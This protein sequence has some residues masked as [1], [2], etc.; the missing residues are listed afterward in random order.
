MAGRAMEGQV[1]ELRWW[2]AYLWTLVLTRTPLGPARAYLVARAPFG[3]RLAA[4]ALPGQSLVEY[5]LVI[6]VIALV[7]IAGLTAF[8]NGITQ[9]FTT[10]LGRVTGAVG[11]G[12]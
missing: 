10:I 8:G 2:T 12:R 3:W 1:S 7:A 9:V 4:A 5:A 6:G 11:G